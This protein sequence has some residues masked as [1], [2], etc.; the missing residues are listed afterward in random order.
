M[1]HDVRLFGA[2]ARKKKPARGGRKP[3]AGSTP[4][5]SGTLGRPEDDTD[6]ASTAPTPGWIPRRRVF[7]CQPADRAAR[8]AARP[9][10][11]RPSRRPRISCG[12]EPHRVVVRPRRRCGATG[13]PGLAA[14]ASAPERA[15]LRAPPAGTGDRL[16]K[17]E[18]WR[19]APRAMETRAEA[20][21]RVA[22]QG[23]DQKLASLSS[24]SL[25]PALTALRYFS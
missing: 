13:K 24:K 1:A 17:H 20:M 21:T 16:S 5:R 14:P 8:L 25:S 9:A 2:V 18:V 19:G 12:C 4:A 11:V 10:W 23:G 7:F 15:I 3:R 6:K 22:G